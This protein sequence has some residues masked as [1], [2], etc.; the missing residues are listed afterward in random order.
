MHG[1]I[2]LHMLDFG[3]DQDIFSS[4]A[5]PILA[6]H[7]RVYDIVDMSKPSPVQVF[8]EPLLTGADGTR[9]GVTHMDGSLWNGGHIRHSRVRASM[10]GR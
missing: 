2:I 5:N 10:V 6:L 8:H 9:G 4:L 1:V 7:S 3:V